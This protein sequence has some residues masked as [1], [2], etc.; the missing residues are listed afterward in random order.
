MNVLKS[1]DLTSI[2]T[3]MGNSV[4]FNGST[5][6]KETCFS[7]SLGDAMVITQLPIFKILETLESLLWKCLKMTIRVISVY[8]DVIWLPT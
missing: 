3:C 6:Y 5:F 1:A 2:L 4:P 8:P 7:A